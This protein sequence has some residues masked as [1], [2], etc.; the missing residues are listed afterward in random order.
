MINRETL[1]A[2]RSDIKKYLRPFLSAQYKDDIYVLGNIIHA[3]KVVENILILADSLE[4][5]ENEKNTAEVVA[6]FHDIGRFW[7]LLQDQVEKKNYDHADAGIQ[8]LLT[9][10]TFNSLDE[11]VK[12]NLTEVIQNHHLPKITQKEN[13]LVWFYLRLLRDAD[14]LDLWRLTTDHLANVKKRELLARELGL[15]DKLMVT[16]SYSRNILEG[17]IAEKNEIVTFSDYLLY[18]MSWV[19]DLNFR[20]SFQLLNQRQYM[21]HYY[22]ALPKND[23][24]FGIYR[25]IKI[26][27]ENQIL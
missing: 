15:N 6:L 23:L 14:K 24:V 4:L 21:R 3:E 19:F 8:Y 18:Q 1:E 25:K 22:D 9:N 20:K 26:H 13:S 11:Q 12:N 10:N 5:S 7:V 16:E 17:G 2:F 27:I